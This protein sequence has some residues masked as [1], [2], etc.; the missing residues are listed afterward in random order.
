MSQ[1]NFPP[2]RLFDAFAKPASTEQ[3]AKKGLLGKLGLGESSEE[4][5]YTTVMLVGF[6]SAKEPPGNGE[7]A[8]DVIHRAFDPC[9]ESPG[10]D[11][12]DFYD[13]ASVAPQ[14]LNNDDSESTVLVWPKI[15][16]NMVTIPERRLRLLVVTGPAPSLCMQRFMTRFFKYVK[17]LHVDH[18]IFVE[19]F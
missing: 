19:T 4:D 2:A 7:D 1:P 18:A 5:N 3:P 10:F 9:D 17:K 13:Y 11:M 15:F 8:L 14:L 16:Y 6:N 12:D